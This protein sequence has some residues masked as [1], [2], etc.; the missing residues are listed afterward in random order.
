MTDNTR[1]CGTFAKAGIHRGTWTKSTL[2]HYT[3]LR[4]VEEVMARFIDPAVQQVFRL[5]YQFF[6]FVHFLACGYNVVCHDHNPGGEI[7]LD[8]RGWSEY[9]IESDSVGRRNSLFAR[10]TATFYFALSA[11]SGEY[12]TPETDSEIGYN[13]VCLVCGVVINAV[14]IGSVASLLAASDTQAAELKRRREHM[15]KFM[16]DHKVG[17]RGRYRISFPAP[18]FSPN[19]QSRIEC[20]PRSW[21]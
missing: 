2:R 3:T 9:S 7:D 18:L 20:C 11:V 6:L 4:S 15:S 16:R 13:T 8:G 5:I 10:W 19:V 21:V 17:E 12:L 14:I 1:M